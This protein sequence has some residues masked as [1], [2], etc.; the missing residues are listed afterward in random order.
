MRAVAFLMYGVGSLSGGG[1]AERFFADFFSDYATDPR[2]G[3]RCYFILDARSLAELERIGRIKSKKGVLRFR[4]FP[5]RFKVVMEG[6]A[7]LR[8][9]LS[10]RIDILHIPLYDR[11]YVPL[12]EWIDR[13][14][15][16][17][18]PRLVINI[19]NCYVAPALADTNNRYHI[20]MTKTYRPIFQR[21]RIDG[22]FCW[23]RNFEDYA[24]ANSNLFK[25]APEQVR[26]IRSRYAN[27]GLYHASEKKQKWV[28]F[29]S[30]MDAQKNPHWIILA[31][32]IIAECSPASLSGWRFKLC[33]DGPLRNSVID[34]AQKMGV[35][36]YIDFLVV[37]EMHRVLNPSMIYVSTQ[38]FENFPSLAMAEAM[39][40]GNAIVARDVG[41]TSLFLQNGFNGILI[42]PDSPEGLASALMQLMTDA[43]LVERM[44][45]FSR[46]LIDNTHN[47]SNFV[48]QI[49]S[50]WKAVLYGGRRTQ[51]HRHE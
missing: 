8:L 16:W 45:K 34:L 48:S 46:H 37:S 17:L 6:L 5:N 1:G 12:L 26:S 40:S 31:L 24:K 41:Q 30:R 28:V 3:F 14:P 11:S 35:A 25:R 21:V 22:Y 50:F 42:H 49:E 23:N 4:F 10:Y 18:R 36:S 19:V 2:A 27:I 33:G 44:G 20:S 47:Y 13:L 39:A 38:E 32:G 15:S 51:D 7:L 9:I 43:A 29:A